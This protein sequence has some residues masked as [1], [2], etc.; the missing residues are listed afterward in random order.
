[1]HRHKVWFFVMRALTVEEGEESVLQYCH[2]GMRDQMPGK[3]TIYSHT[4]ARLTGG[5]I[6]PVSAGNLS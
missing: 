6:N 1:M 2:E 3:R 4:R 5:A